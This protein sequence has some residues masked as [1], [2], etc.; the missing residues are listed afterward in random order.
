MH[1]KG[2]STKWRPFCLGLYGLS[3]CH[4]TNGYVALFKPMLIGHV[5]GTLS[6]A[7]GLQALVWQMLAGLLIWDHGTNEWDYI[8][9]PTPGGILVQKFSNSGP[10]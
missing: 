10:Q 9:G 2:S 8:C 1:L 4:I 3:Q 6:S 7:R 5:L